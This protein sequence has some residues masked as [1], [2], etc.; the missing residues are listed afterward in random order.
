MAGQPIKLKLLNNKMLIWIRQISNAANLFYRRHKLYT[1]HKIFCHMPQLFNWYSVTLC[2]QIS[3]QGIQTPVGLSTGSAFQN[4]PYAVVHWIEME[5]Y[6]V[7]SPAVM[8]SEKCSA[9]HC[10][11]LFALWAGAESCWKILN[12]RTV[13]FLVDF[14]TFYR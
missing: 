7:H 14:D 12:F 2:H 11:V 6:G 4:W 9:H 8:K 3:L 10:C 5:E 13:Y 1:L